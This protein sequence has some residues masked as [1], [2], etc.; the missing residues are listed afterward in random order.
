MSQKIKQAAIWGFIVG[1]AMGV[2]Y[3]F[4]DRDDM[5]L[6]PAMGMKAFGT[7]HQPAGTWSDDTSMMLCVI[8][9]IKNNGSPKDLAKLFIRWFDD[10]YHTAHGEV[11]D[12]GI[13]TRNAIVKLKTGIPASKSGATDE[14]SAGN[15]SL[16]RCLPYAFGEDFRKSMYEMIIDNNIT[17]RLPICNECCMFYAKVIQAIQLGKGKED[18]VRAGAAFLKFGRRIV[19][20]DD[21]EAAVVYYAK[22]KRILSDDFKFLPEAAIKSTGYVLH[23]LE[24]AIWC[25]L[26]TNNYSEAVLKAVNL[27]GDTDTIAAVTGGMAAAYYGIDNI[28][29]EWLEQIVRKK[30]IENLIAVI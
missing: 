18:A 10:G 11:F 6:E 19:D 8:E 22:F 12:I 25:F 16:M 23:T 26:N 30:D 5:K 14:F 29:K 15:G 2:P 27:G 17:H 28:P 1:D 4:I 7:H 9:N 21:D 13:T 24:A 3:E 20:S